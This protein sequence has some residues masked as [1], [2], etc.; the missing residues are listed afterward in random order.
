MPNCYVYIILGNAPDLEHEADFG[1][2]PHRNL[3]PVCRANLNTGSQRTN[4]NIGRSRVGEESPLVYHGRASGHGVR[5]LQGNGSVSQQHAQAPEFHLFDLQQFVFI[6]LGMPN[7]F[8]DRFKCLGSKFPNSNC[9][10]RIEHYVKNKN[11][12]KHAS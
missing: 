9:R 10:W 4:L 6:S 12:Q 11:K 7:V 3:D 2:Q 1:G 5:N 8:V